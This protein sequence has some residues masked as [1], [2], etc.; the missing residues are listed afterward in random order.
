MAA[1]H[2][3]TVLAQMQEYLP[4]AQCSRDL[5]FWRKEQATITPTLFSPAALYFDRINLFPSVDGKASYNPSSLE[6]KLGTIPLKGNRELNS[7]KKSYD[8]LLGLGYAR[9]N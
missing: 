9:Y 1:P 7:D 6:Q 4:D 8:F 5:Y 2:Y 3:K